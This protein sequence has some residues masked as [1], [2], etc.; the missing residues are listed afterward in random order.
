LYATT[1]TKTKTNQALQRGVG[2]WLPHPD[3]LPAAIARKRAGLPPGP[4]QSAAA[5]FRRAATRVD[6]QAAGLSVVLCDDKPST[7][8]AP[9]ILQAAAAPLL[10]LHASERRLVDAAPEVAGRLEAGGLSVAFLN[11]SSSRFV[12]MRF[13]CVPRGCIGCVDWHNIIH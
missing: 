12:C 9:D 5:E 8:G 10:L 4:P 7:F 2:A 1:L 11:N 6:L 3:L 13:L